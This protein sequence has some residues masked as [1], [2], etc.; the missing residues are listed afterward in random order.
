[1][2]ETS[3]IAVADRLDTGST[4]IYHLKRLW[5]KVLLGLQTNPQYAQEQELDSSLIDLLGLGLLPTYQFLYSHRPSFEAFEQW[6]LQQSGGS[7]NPEK[8]QQCN[9]LVNGNSYATSDDEQ[10]VLTVADIQFWHTYGYVIVR[11]AIPQADCAA[12]R[13][14]IWEYLNMDENDSDTWYHNADTV[15]GIMVPLYR[16]PAIDKNRNAPKIR[17]A[18]EQLWGQ[19]GLV[20]TTDKCGFNPPETGSF[21]YRGIGL[22]WDVSLAQPIPFG[23]QGILYLTDTAAH[24]GALTVVPSFHHIIA[25]WLTNLPNNCH[26]RTADLSAFEKKPIAANAGDCIIWNHLLPHSSSPN[27]ANLPRLVQYI[28]WYSPLQKVHSEWI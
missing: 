6:V 13:Q 3:P 1:M 22:H 14:A 12:A 18:F 21:R 16:H 7:I 23:T 28:N 2:K 4:G 8:I 25:N 24:Q 27:T 11:N 26:P 19:K 15:Q 9:Q 17:K 10:E 20:V 5:G